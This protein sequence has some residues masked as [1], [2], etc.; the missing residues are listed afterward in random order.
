MKQEIFDIKNVKVFFNENQFWRSIPDPA[1]IIIPQ[2]DYLNALLYF[3]ETNKNVLP[4]WDVI[5]LFMIGVSRCS[6]YNTV[7]LG[8]ELQLYTQEDLDMLKNY[9]NGN[10]F[11]SIDDFCNRYN[12]N[13]QFCIEYFESLQWEFRIRSREEEKYLNDQSRKQLKITEIGQSRELKKAES[14][15]IYVIANGKKY[16]IGKTKNFHNR[17][18]QLCT[19]NPNELEVIV[20]KK[21]TNY[22]EIEELLLHKYSDKRISGEWFLLKEEDILDIKQILDTT[23]E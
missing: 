20:L 6:K 13:K 23:N 4:E 12:L 7:S 10:S 1:V 11:W 19:S 5:T 16:K 18:Q 17:Y 21:I 2:L 14:G 15:F 3:L 9:L 22:H 8:S